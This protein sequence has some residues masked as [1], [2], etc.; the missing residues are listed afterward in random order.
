MKTLI[1]KIA[2][3]GTNYSGWQIQPNAIT[4]Q[5]EIQ[6]AF[7]NACGFEIN[8]IAAGR[9]DSGVHAAA[10]IASCEIE[11]EIKIPIEKLSISLNAFLEKDIRIINAKISE[12]KF[13]ARFDAISRCYIYQL[14]TV[15]DV[16]K[17]RYA[18]STKYKIDLD[19]LFSSALIFRGM[20]DYTTFSKFNESI[21]NNIC[22]V[23]I[24]QWEKLEEG[25]YNLTIRANHFLYGMVRSIVGTMIDIARG[26][27]SEEE[28]RDS[29]SKKDRNLNSPL[30]PSCGLTFMKADYE[31]KIF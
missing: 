5:S 19:K 24:C 1:L 28:V 20:N 10:M 26:K 3:D 22:N 21:K 17:N 29:L 13:H 4:I 15:D 25:H 11:N 16:F 31:Q 8:L 6:R 27:K 18:H 7:Y 9:T 30:A 14:L 12:D 2:Y 23:D